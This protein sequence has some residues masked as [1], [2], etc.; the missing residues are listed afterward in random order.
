MTTFF[1]MSHQK[2][3]QTSWS[4]KLFFPTAC[5]ISSCVVGRTT[6]VDGCWHNVGGP[7]CFGWQKNVS[8]GTSKKIKSNLT[9][10]SHQS[11]DGNMS[12]VPATSPRKIVYDQ[13]TWHCLKLKCA[14]F[15][16]CQGGWCHGVKSE[17]GTGGG[18]GHRVVREISCMSRQWL[19]GNMPWRE[20]KP[21]YSTYCRHKQKLARPKRSA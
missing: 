14:I 4:D 7:I 20:A 9:L 15:H 13:K 1:E 3:Q 10:W 12:S 11:E 2:Q 8:H 17:S 21:R 18:H 6:Q 19:S 5:P 16:G